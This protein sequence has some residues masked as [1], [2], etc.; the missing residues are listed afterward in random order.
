MP[1]DN[2]LGAPTEGLGQKVTFAFDVS[3]PPQLQLSSMPALQAGVTGG[4]ARSNTQGSGVRVDVN[5][6]LAILSKLGS[7]LLAP[8]IEKAKTEAF[9]SGMQ[10]A[11]QGEAVADIAKS[12]PWYSK[13]FGDS[14]VVEGARAYAGH[15]TAQTTIAEMEDQMPELRKM[16]PAEA[17]KFFTEAV[18]KNLTGDKPT[19]LSILKA[20]TSAMPSVMRRQAKEH[21][22]WLQ[23]NAT[24]AETA[25]FRAGADRLQ[26]GAKGLREGYTTPEEFDALTRQFVGSLVPAA[27][28]DLDS[29][30]KSM[31]NN[32]Q[33][34]AEG[35]SFHA[36]NAVRDA[37]FFDVLDP[38][39]RTAVEKSIASG[40][41]RLRTRYSFDWNDDLAKIEA[42]ATLPDV[43]QNVSD[44]AK[45]IDALNS[46]YSQET[47]SRQG[48]ISPERRAAMLSGSAVTITREKNRIAELA[49]SNAAKA[50]TTQ[51]K[52]AAAA[53]KRAIIEQR[54]AE[55]TLGTLSANKNYSTEEINEVADGLYRG[56]PPDERVKFLVSNMRENYV[57]DSVK[58]VRVGQ[59]TAAL[60]S[61]NIDTFMPAFGEYAKLREANKFAAAQYYGEYAERLEGFYN[62]IQNG[63]APAGALR[64]RFTG[65]AARSRLSKDEM[66]EALKVVGA[67]QNWFMRQ[68]T[69]EQK[70]KPGTARRI[71][72]EISESVERFA[73]ATGN[74]KDATELA[75]HSAKSN[76]LEVMGGY[77]W[78]NG[79]G[80]TSLEKYLTT[81]VGPQGEAPRA[82][83]KVNEEVAYAIDELLYG[84]ADT[85][86]ILP[87]KASDSVVLRLP[88]KAGVP[89]FHVQSIVDGKVY[90]GVL[91][92]SDIFALA[93]KRRKRQ[94]T[95]TLGID[96]DSLRFGP[97]F[98]HPKPPPGGSIYR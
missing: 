77:A 74:V 38:E 93:E 40:E 22:G 51:D 23:E 1:K 20:M 94:A 90:N 65:P 61:E 14:D 46:R 4:D 17:Q 76:G 68:W 67:G 18:Q 91:A 56:L 84:D 86:G 34:W 55:G 96:N 92:G 79:K 75:L 95:S 35:G 58:K 57:I 42:Q 44:I 36:L 52:A 26:A 71:V 69:G 89:M 12:Q 98:S 5:P 16:A 85:S 66:K 72:N 28:R 19:D 41:S 3:A 53:E 6:T 33:L 9:V 70:M 64:D 87:D 80:Q 82:T 15:T 25:A 39:Q 83:D 29:Y 31:A 49:A 59:I 78:T 45:Q 21:Y 8:V 62:D 10:R 43:G 24:A 60:G 7:E 54:A 30:K 32:L 48:L 2:T 47:G 11:M 27:G 63:L 50:A 13:L 73:N 81:T 88:D 37:G 97:K